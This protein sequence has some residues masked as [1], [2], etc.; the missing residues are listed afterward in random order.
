MHKNLSLWRDHSAVRFLFF[1]FLF[2]V[3]SVTYK[4]NRH[5][6]LHWH[7]LLLWHN[8]NDLVLVS[9]SWS[10]FSAFVLVRSR[11]MHVLS[12]VTVSPHYIPSQQDWRR[13]KA[14]NAHHL[15]LLLIQWDI[16]QIKL[17]IAVKNYL[18]KLFRAKRISSMTFFLLVTQVI[19]TLKIKGSLSPC[20]RQK[21]FITVLSLL[22][23]LKPKPILIEFYI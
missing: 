12:P 22:R 20:S 18:I 3:T 15:S 7:K 14:S 16:G 9:V 13:T 5:I 1:L 10:S 4:F 23:P 11:R 19:W 8:L 2:S 21:D 17:Q 6:T